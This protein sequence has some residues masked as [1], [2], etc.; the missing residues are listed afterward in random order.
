MTSTQR[1]AIV[2]KTGT[3]TG[4]TV[5]AYL[6]SN[7]RVTGETPEQVSIAG[8]DNAGWTLDGY[9]I[10]RL[11]SGMI[12]AKES[13]PGTPGTSACTMSAVQELHAR[14][15][16]AEE[17]IVRARYLSN[18]IMAEYADAG[19]AY[20]AALQQ[21]DFASASRIHREHYDICRPQINARLEAELVAAGVIRVSEHRG[22]RTWVYLNL[23]GERVCLRCGKDLTDE[24]GCYVWVEGKSAPDHTTRGGS[25]PQ[26]LMCVDHGA[27]G[28]STLSRDE[29]I[30]LYRARYGRDPQ[31]PEGQQS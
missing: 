21:A 22:Q 4:A 25:G 18:E 30:K 17:A 6:P 9:V 23:N 7:Y 2:T 16:T 20:F 26:V 15:D 10:P 14:L 3:V 27:N 24:S 11:A 29:F 13:F 12:F 31:F 5:A 19:H 1:Y 28:A 8:Q